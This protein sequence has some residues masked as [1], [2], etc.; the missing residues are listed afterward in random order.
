MAPE[1]EAPRLAL[2]DMS[3]LFEGKTIGRPKNLFLPGDSGSESGAATPLERGTPSSRVRGVP[4]SGGVG[5]RVRTTAGHSVVCLTSP[6]S[7]RPEGRPELA[8]HLQ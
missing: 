7:P 8:Q 1:L 4:R 3:L 2:H 5:I 6:G